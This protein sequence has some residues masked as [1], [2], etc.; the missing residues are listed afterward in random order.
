MDIGRTAF[1]PV[2]S[3]ILTSPRRTA[4]H[5]ADIFNII[6]E[7]MEKSRQLLNLVLIRSL[8]HPVYKGQFLPV[9]MLRHGLVGRQHKILNHSGGHIALIRPDLPGHPLF[10]QHNL[11]FREIKINAAPLPPLFPQ[12]RRQGLHLPEHG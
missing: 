12:Q 8:V 6:S 4:S 2:S 3:D 10:I 1:R 7:I 5:L 9:K 11:A